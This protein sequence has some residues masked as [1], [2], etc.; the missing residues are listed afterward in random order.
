MFFPTTEPATVTAVTDSDLQTL[1]RSQPVVICVLA[2]GIDAGLRLSLPSIEAGRFC[3][4][5]HP[6][7]R[8]GSRGGNHCRWPP[9]R[10]WP[11][12]DTDDRYVPLA[13][14][15]GH[16]RHRAHRLCFCS[17]ATT[18]ERRFHSA[19]VILTCFTP[20]M[21]VTDND[22]RTVDTGNAVCMG[23]P[24]GLFGESLTPGRDSLHL[25]AFRFSWPARFC[26]RFIQP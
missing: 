15:F 24:A 21:Q 1:K 10:P 2:L 8:T 3:Y 12:L 18:A 9:H 19:F 25:W 5:L 26:L 7:N 17:D 14:S 22:P 6:R 13:D 4:A 16:N 11:F 23:K 20:V